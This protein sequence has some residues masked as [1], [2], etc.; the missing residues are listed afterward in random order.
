MAKK[1]AQG[2]NSVDSDVS[3]SSSKNQDNEIMSA[4]PGPASLPSTPRVAAAKGGASGGIVGS[5]PTARVFKGSQE[6][7]HDLFKLKVA[8]MKR[9]VSYTDVPIIDHIEHVHIFHTIDSSGKRQTE[10]TPVG[11][12]FHQIEVHHNAMG[13]PHLVV[14]PAMK[15]VK[16]RVKGQ[17]KAKRVAVPVRWQIGEDEWETDN[18]THQ[19]EYL[20]S[21]MIHLRKSNPEAAKAETAIRMKMEPPPV[22]GVMTGRK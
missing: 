1:G 18:H 20:G 19:S 12:H 2:R 13:V 14:G 21:E 10:S 8:S 15:W 17:R 7:P 9:N 5:E 11:G 22:E 3:E 4:D 16:K 6:L